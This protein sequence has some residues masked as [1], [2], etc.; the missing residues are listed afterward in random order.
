MNVVAT[1]DGQTTARLRCL[2]P[3]IY[4]VIIELAHYS[5]EATRNDQE[6]AEVAKPLSAHFISNQ[7]L[8]Y[9]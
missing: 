4:G 3:A 9:P 2:C 5:V 1:P 8:T 6:H 7:K